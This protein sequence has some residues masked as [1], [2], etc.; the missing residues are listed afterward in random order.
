MMARSDL[1]QPRLIETLKAGDFF[2]ELSLVSDEPTPFWVEASSDGHVLFLSPDDFR[3]FLREHPDTVFDV[4]N[5]LGKR[6][7]RLEQAFR[8][9]ASRDVNELNADRLTTGQRV[10]DWFANVIGSWP[11]IIIQSVILCIWIVLN[12]VGWIKAWDPYPFILLNLALSFQAAYAGPIIMMSQNRQNDKDRLVASIDHNVN[13]KS[14]L[15]IG[16]LLRKIEAV[17]RVLRRTR[18]TLE[19]PPPSDN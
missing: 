16:L 1:Q 5:V 9:H 3:E 2:G 12:V 14:E 7:M 11:F 4:F 10:A 15:E 17:E 13:L 6:L 18:P 8:G 19:N